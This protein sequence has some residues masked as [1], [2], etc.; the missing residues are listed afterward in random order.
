MRRT[1]ITSTRKVGLDNHV[2]TL[3]ILLSNLDNHVSRLDNHVSRVKP[4]TLINIEKTVQMKPQKIQKYK[5]K[6]D[7][8]KKIANI[9]VVS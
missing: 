2:S 8:E 9:Q 6:I 1:N 3:D 7:S 5:N 4:P